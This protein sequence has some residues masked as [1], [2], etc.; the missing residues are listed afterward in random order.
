MTWTSDALVLEANDLVD[1]NLT[2]QIVVDAYTIDINSLGSTS[3]R[4]SVSDDY[5]DLA[6]SIYRSG[7]NRLNLANN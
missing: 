7:G 2:S 5:G 4:A 1:G 3:I 6:G